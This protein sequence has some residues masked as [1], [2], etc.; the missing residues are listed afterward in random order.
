MPPQQ[1]AAPGGYPPPQQSQYSGDSASAPTQAIPAPSFGQQQGFGQQQAQN[2]YGAPQEAPPN[3][4][5][6]QPPQNPFGTAQPMPAPGTPYGQQPNPLGY[7]AVPNK[8]GFLRRGNL[9]KLRL[10]I[11]LVVLA[12][13]GVGWFISH[14]SDP[15]TASAGDCVHISG[16]DANS[17]KKVS[18]GDSSA[19]YTVVQKFDGTSD[20]DKCKPLVQANPNMVALYQYGKSEYVLCLSPK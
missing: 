2:P 14:K 9:G 13:I 3:P 17:A 19:N 4:Y 12:V 5:G 10:I 16:S 15:A 8:G 1:E 11:S 7:T 20:T 18:C 6:Q